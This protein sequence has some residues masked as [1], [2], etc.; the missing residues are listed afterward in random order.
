VV[1]LVVAFLVG[2]G[3]LLGGFYLLSTRRK[4]RRQLQALSYR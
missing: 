4:V 1:V 2:I 3:F